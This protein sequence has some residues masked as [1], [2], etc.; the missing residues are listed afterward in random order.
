MVWCTIIS[1]DEQP[2]S[3]LRPH[4]EP[5]AGESQLQRINLA[6]RR[7]RRAPSN[8]VPA[9]W[10]EGREARVKEA[11]VVVSEA[12]AFSKQGVSCEAGKQRHA[13]RESARA[14]RRGV[15]RPN[16]GAAAGRVACSC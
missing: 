1:T 6:T 4:Q 15:G 10:G 7:S 3:E 13:R 5:L 14:A 12:A 16:A 8:G 9:P 11:A 2:V